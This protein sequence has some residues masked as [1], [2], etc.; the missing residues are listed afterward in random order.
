MIFLASVGSTA[1]FIGLFGTVWGIMHSFSSIA[2]MQEHQPFAVVA[3]RHRGGAVRH[4]DRP[5]G[6][7][8]GRAGVQQDQHQTCRA[9]PPGME[10]FGTEFGAI[11]SRQSEERA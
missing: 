11:L 7:D 2:A 6:G 3:P 9:S 8:P 1:P 10:G 4:G 5:G